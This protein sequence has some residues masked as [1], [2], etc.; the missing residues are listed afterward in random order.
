MSWKER[1]KEFGSIAWSVLGIIT[2]VI[3]V[4]G[5]LSFGIFESAK[6]DIKKHFKEKHGISCE[7][8]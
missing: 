1:I 5:L 3:L 6:V 2:A 7:C 4:I 8:K